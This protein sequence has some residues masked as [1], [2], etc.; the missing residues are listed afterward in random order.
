MEATAPFYFAEPVL[1]TLPDRT[2]LLSDD[3][4]AARAS[5]GVPEALTVLVE[6]YRGRVF[7]FS[8]A[9]L[10]DRDDAED[11][12]QETFVRAF[13]ALDTYRGRG[14]FRAWLFRIAGNHCRDR[15][16]AHSRRNRS[17]EEPEMDRLLTDDGK[18]AERF[19]L[20]AAVFDAVVSLPV[21]YRAPV[22]LHYMEGM[23]VAETAAALGRSSTAVKVQLWR[24]RGLL[25]DRLIDWGPQ[26]GPSQDRGLR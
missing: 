2:D 18:G 6:R 5:G 20:R 7:A 3:D 26:T 22:V 10:R 16:K 11:A 25:A 9:M 19:V 14:Q 23:S 21:T 8:L 17:L 13:A 15:L 1:D 12:V 24:A 4:L